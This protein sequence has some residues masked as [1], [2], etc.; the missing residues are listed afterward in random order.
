M[1]CIPEI[2]FTSVDLPAPLSPTSATTSPARTS[3]STPCSACTG[4]KCF[5]TSLRARIAPFELPFEVIRRSPVSQ[6][7]GGPR[8]A[9]RPWSQ[10]SDACR[11]ACAGK[12]ALAEVG[13]AHVAALHDL[14]DVG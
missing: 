14:V 3:K 1:R 11:L 10:L 13:L 2:D 7:R 6:S 5:E 4:P 9:A 12:R 8:D